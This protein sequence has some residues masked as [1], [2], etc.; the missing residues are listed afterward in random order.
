MHISH[1][2]I[3]L[4]EFNSTSISQDKVDSYYITWTI[5]KYPFVTIIIDGSARRFSWSVNILRDVLG[6]W[7][8]GFFLHL[9]IISSLQTSFSTVY[10]HCSDNGR[11]KLDI[12]GVLNKNKKSPIWFLPYFSFRWFIL[13]LYRFFFLWIIISAHTLWKLWFQVMMIW[14]QNLSHF[15]IE[16]ILKFF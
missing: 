13:R 7:M 14:V 2:Q 5:N 11:C 9:E 6:K 12:C 3:L 1:C 10:P 8:L 15:L 4:H 16:K